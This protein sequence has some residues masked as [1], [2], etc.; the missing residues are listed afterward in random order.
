MRVKTSFGVGRLFVVRRSFRL[1]GAVILPR[2]WSES[3]LPPTG[4]DWHEEPAAVQPVSHGNHHRVSGISIKAIGTPKTLSNGFAC[5]V[6]M[7]LELSHGIEIRFMPL[8]GARFL[9]FAAE[10]SASAVLMLCHLAWRCAD[11]PPAESS[12]HSRPTPA[13]QGVHV[14]HTVC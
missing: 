7:L 14:L 4:A 5:S 9:D 3:F 8:L 6:L 12:A 10:S 1:R 11:S 13:D 2:P